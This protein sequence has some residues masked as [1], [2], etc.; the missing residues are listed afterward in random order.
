MQG[1]CQ[2]L[3]VQ[4]VGQ[5]LDS[6][7]P[8]QDAVA[9]GPERIDQLVGAGRRPRMPDEGFHRCHWPGLDAEGSGNQ[10][11]NAAFGSAILRRTRPVRL[12][13]AAV[14]HHLVTEHGTHR[15]NRLGQGN[16]VARAGCGNRFLEAVGV[17]KHVTDR[18]VDL[19]AQFQ[20]QRIV[21]Q[22]EIL[23]RLA[24][25]ETAVVAERPAGA[26]VVGYRRAVE[27]AQV[28]VGGERAH[29]G[30]AL[31]NFRQQWSFGVADHGHS[32]ATGL[33]VFDRESQVIQESRTGAGV[34][35]GRADTAEHIGVDEIGGH[36]VQ[37]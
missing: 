21:E 36:G 1:D 24:E 26:P 8:G 19:R 6:L 23:G 17:N 14:A 32:P 13:E 10:I 37:P 16:V 25:R 5:T 7:N 34:G 3:V 20:R 31:D 9:Q 27:T 11:E 15:G 35:A 4:I 29:G 18:A 30:I 2:V 28:V 22:H 12:D 33:D